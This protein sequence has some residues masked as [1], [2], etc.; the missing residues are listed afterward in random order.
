P[1][2]VRI[3]GRR[4]G[5]HQHHPRTLQ[6]IAVPSLI[7]HQR[8]PWVGEQVLGV[9]GKTREEEQRRAISRC[10]D[11]DEGAIGITR[12]DHQGR[13][14][15]GSG[16][17]QELLGYRLGVEVGRWLHRGCAS[18]QSTISAVYQYPYGARAKKTLDIE[19]TPTDRLIWRVRRHISA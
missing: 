17:T 7:N 2:R 13:Q 5:A 14:C 1:P 3:S 12:G 6:R 16:L 9:N 19:E 8:D 4:S 11:V 15:A 18:L 10:C